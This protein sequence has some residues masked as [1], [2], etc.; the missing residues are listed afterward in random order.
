MALARTMRRTRPIGRPT[1]SP[2]FLLLSFEGV[3][4]EGEG[5]GEESALEEMERRVKVGPS[6]TLDSLLPG[7]ST[8]RERVRLAVDSL[9]SQRAF[10]LR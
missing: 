3:V 1:F 9:L 6:K 4:D 10:M 8:T 2:S 7:W 5:L